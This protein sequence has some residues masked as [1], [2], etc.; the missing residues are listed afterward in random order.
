M[1]NIYNEEC[2]EEINKHIKWFKQEYMKNERNWVEVD[3]R[4]S[5][6]LEIR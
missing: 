2:D 5:K 1:G 4:M 6:T 3:N